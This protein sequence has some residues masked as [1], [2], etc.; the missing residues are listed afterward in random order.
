MT[1]FAVIAAAVAESLVSFSGVFFVLLHE[2]LAKRIA[3][4][5]LGF[6]IG[7]LMGATFFEII[8]E[9]A[10]VI[11]LENTLQYVLGGVIVF[12]VIEKVFRWHHHHG[13]HDGKIRPYTALILIGD[14][15]HNFIDGVILAAGF[16]I[17]VPF[18]VA[19]TVAVLAHEVPQEIAD[20]AVLIRGGYPAAR[21][22]KLN[23][24][25]SLTTIAGALAGYLGGSFA[26][27]WLP[28]IL[29]VIGGNFLYI[30]L[31]DLIPE[32]HET[33]GAGHIAVQL[34]LMIAGIYLMALL[35]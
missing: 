19:T 1:L 12:F 33:V 25:V 30:A 16:L 27:A 14:A 23:F 28:H 15:I 13:G 9:S 5:V 6:A 22:L 32:A 2:P 11:G 17:S 31:S 3:H 24:F 34:A 18:G 4:R 35:A 10:G 21:A 29:G 20:F 7:T 8:P 26:A